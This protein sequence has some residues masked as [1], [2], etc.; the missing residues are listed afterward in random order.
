M[1]GPR[2]LLA[3]DQ[4]DV[5][6][7]LRLLLK[8]EGYDTICVDHPEAAI[9]SALEGPPSLVVM[10][11]NYTRDTTSGQE[12]LDLLARL[13]Q[14][15]EPPPVIVMT[16]WGTLDIAV[17]AMRRGARD[18]IIKPWDNQ[19][20]LETVK[21]HL[22]DGA[23]PSDMLA[24][25]LAIARQVQAKL[26]PQRRPVLSTLRVDGD[27]RQAG[28]VGGDSFDYLDLGTGRVG[29]V[30]ADISGKGVAAALLMAN[31]QATLRNLAWQAPTSLPTLLRTV[32]V[33]FLDS[34]TPERYTTLFFG[35]YD[36]ATRTLRYA[37]C[38]HPAPIVLRKSGE[39]VR[40]HSTAPVLGLI[41]RFQP[42]VGEIRMEPGDLLIVYSDGAS[43]PF[44]DEE[45]TLLRFVR[46][47]RAGG[48]AAITARLAAAQPAQ[49]DDITVL[50]AE[51]L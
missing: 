42:E 34:T 9:R 27:C 14:L 19:R 39:V 7:A 1:P 5:L 23:A 30:L 20:L 17:E 26:L 38:G 45:E 11:L 18:F 15:P 21:K 24:R 3:D 37:N 51:G 25:D 44:E 46:D 40:L 6:M 35:D 43:E 22:R 10:D 16:A 49:A 2:I 47:E 31:L 48:A 41:E 32:N 29:L 28:L 13:H 36:D 33:Q 50:L 8:P 12:G 4:P